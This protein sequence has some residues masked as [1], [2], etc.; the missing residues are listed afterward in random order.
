[1]KNTITMIFFII[2]CLI[3]LSGIFVP[4]GK[5]FYVFVTSIMCLGIG[6]HYAKSN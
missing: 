3:M 6:G 2:A 4:D 1:M 5:G